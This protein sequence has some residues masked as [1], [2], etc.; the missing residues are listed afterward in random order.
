MTD[1]PISGRPRFDPVI[2][3]GHILVAFSIMVSGVALY[4]SNEVR[5]TDL[6]LRVRT[7][8]SLIVEYRSSAD[9]M[10]DR[11]TD[12]LVEI[13]SIKVRLPASPAPPAQR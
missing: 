11:L 9:K 1:P 8:E 2:T 4:A 13:A 6:N 7:I 12:I 10:T 3:W 5:Y